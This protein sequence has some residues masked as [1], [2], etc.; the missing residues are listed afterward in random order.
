MDEPLLTPEQVSEMLQIPVG[1]LYAWRY[2]G[3]G[4]PSSRCGRHIRY[5]RAAV[6]KWVLDR[7]AAGAR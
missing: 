5:R 4:P 6:E 3:Q 1:T 2:R 7:E